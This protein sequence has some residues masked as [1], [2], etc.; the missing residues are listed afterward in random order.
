[1]QKY[2]SHNLNKWARILEPVN[3]KGGS[4]KAAGMKESNMDHSAGNRDAL[5]D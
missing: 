1:M 3:A 4:L 2:V 5:S